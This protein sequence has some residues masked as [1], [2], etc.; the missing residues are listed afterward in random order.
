[1]NND[2][3]KYTTAVFWKAVGVVQTFSK[4]ALR[5]KGIYVSSSESRNRW[6]SAIL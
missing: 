1:M 5:R 3:T 6:I 4:P 2:Q